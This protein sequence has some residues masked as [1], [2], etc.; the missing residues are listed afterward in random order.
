MHTLRDY[1][2][3][4]PRAV[5]FRRGEVC[6]SKNLICRMMIY[7]KRYFAD[8][9]DVVTGNSNFILKKHLEEGFFSKA[10]KYVV[11]NSLSSE[12]V[13]ASK[14]TGSNVNFGFIGQ[15]SHHKGIEFLLEVFKNKKNINI[16]VFGKGI[17]PDYEKYLN[18]RFCSKNILFFGFTPIEEAFRK[19]DILIVPSLWHDPL[20]RVIYEAYSYGI[21]V[22]ASNRGGNSEI[23]DN[24]STGYVYEADSQSDLIRKIEMFITDPAKVQKMRDNCLRKARDFLPE[25]SVKKY[26]DIYKRMA[27][28]QRLL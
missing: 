14:K 2:L 19:I 8:L 23:I 3:I 4:C 15:L 1:A 20:P 24:G 10:K 27:K 28:H 26:A 16:D 21:P 12:E 13:R 22:I 5:L 18:E 6:S 11:Y 7:F 9:P 17:T 25:K